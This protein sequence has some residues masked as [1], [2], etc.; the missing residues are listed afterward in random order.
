[1]RRFNIS[2]ILNGVKGQYDNVVSVI[3]AS[4]NPYDIASVSSVLL[5]V[6]ASM[7]DQLFDPTM[8]VNVV[9]VPQNNAYVETNLS[10]SSQTPSPSQ[11]EPQTSASQGDQSTSAQPLNHSMLIINLTML[12]EEEEVVEVITGISVSAVWEA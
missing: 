9:V 1:M 8:Y 10:T 3:H 11:A 6:E 7:R 2:I 5:V 4:R 12:V